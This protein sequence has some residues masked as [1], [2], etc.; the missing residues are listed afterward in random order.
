MSRTLIIALALIIGVPTFTLAQAQK[1]AQKPANANTEK[2]L[3]YKQQ[4]DLDDAIGYIDVGE[5]VSKQL[6][7]KTKDWKVGDPNLNAATI[8]NYSDSTADALRR[9]GFAEDRFKK[10]PKDHSKVKAEIER[11]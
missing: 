1:A 4:K 7:E 9:I 2:P 3:D 10:L 11:A 8:K 6:D 5:G